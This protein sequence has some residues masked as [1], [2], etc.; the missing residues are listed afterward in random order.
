MVPSP[1]RPPPM[2]M[3]DPPLAAS[4]TAALCALEREPPPGHGFVVEWQLAGGPGRAR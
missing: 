2:A 4:V 3:P 1:P